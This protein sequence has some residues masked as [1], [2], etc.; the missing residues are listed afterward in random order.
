MYRFKGLQRRRK[1]RMLRLIS[2]V[3]AYSKDLKEEKK[4]ESLGSL[5][6]YVLGL[7]PFTRIHV[8]IMSELIHGSLTRACVVMCLLLGYY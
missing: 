3:C 4:E 1:T 6:F 2:L 7:Q 5:L 8:F